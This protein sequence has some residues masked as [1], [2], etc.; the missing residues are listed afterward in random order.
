M[1]ENFLSSA[2]RKQWKKIGVQRRA[3]VITPLFSIYSKN[4]AGIGDFHDLKLLVDWCRQTGL[5]VIQL[6]P[7]NDVGFE[8]RPY[9]AQSTLALDPMY[10]SLGDLAGTDQKKYKRKI[11]A[12]RKAYPVNQKNVNYEIKKAKLQL[13]RSIFE[14]SDRRELEDFQRFAHDE[15]GWLDDYALFKVI[16]EKQEYAGWE[17]WPEALKFRDTR[18]L[19]Q[20]REAH[21]ADFDFQRWLQWQLFCQLR[22]ARQHARAKGVLIMGDL[23]FLV[24][25]NSADIWAHQDYFKLDL[26]SGAPPDPYYAL[27]QRW[28]MPPYHWDRIAADGYQYLKEKLK[29]ASNFYDLYRIDHVVGA[30]RLWTIRLSEPPETN[31]LSGIFDPQDE[32]QWEAHGKNLLSVMIDNCDM[33]PCGEDLGVVPDCCFSVLREMAIPGIDVQRWSRDWKGNFDFKSP[34]QYRENSVATISTHDMTALLAWWKFEAGTVD[35]HLFGR[36]CR[37]CGVNIENVR[38]RLF[39][40]ADSQHGRLRWHK[41]IDSKDKLLEI[42]GKPESEAWE[43][44]GMYRGTYDEKERFWKFLG[45]EGAP[46]NDTGPEFVRR[47]LE[48]ASETSSIFSIQLL[49]DFLCLEDLRLEDLWSFRINFPGTLNPANW[50]L[51]VPYSLEQ[52]TGLSLNEQI[53]R[54]NRET[55]R[56]GNRPFEMVQ[57]AS[58]KDD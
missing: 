35:E 42:L 2:A 10:L 7:L 25:R 31:G 23:P 19:G 52:M 6:L 3:G 18:A 13:L 40:L 58:V 1:Y 36:V 45:F 53:A 29:Y 57:T 24:S 54:M 38:S 46:K 33:L 15:S 34:G 43:P 27:G 17:H 56:A 50:T 4:S 32:S 39:D 5:T 37:D 51:Q 28:G 55:G 26:S 20:F 22:S 49:Q 21:P 30:F 14:S 8:F 41:G 47:A 44:V 16:Q 11:E 48:K 12:L 9:D